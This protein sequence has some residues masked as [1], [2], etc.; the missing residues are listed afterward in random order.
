MSK[1]IVKSLII[2]CIGVLIFT[3]CGGG[4]GSAAPKPV[5]S[6]VKWSSITPPT[7]V[8]LDGIS[9]DATYTA[10]GPSFAVTSITYNGVSSASSTSIKYR[11]DGTIERITV[12]TPYTSVTWDETSGD[13]IDD[14]TVMVAAS[15]PS[16]SN[17]GIAINALHPS[18]GWEYQTFG[19]WETGR[20]TGSGTI[21]AITG[22]AQTT[23]SAIPITGNV[24]FSG[25]AAG[26]Y[27]DVAG[28]ADY[29]T[30]SS[31]SANVNFLNRSINL[32][33]TGTQKINTITAAS[34]SA[35]NLN[36]TGTLTYAPGVNSF[37]GNVSATGLSG[38]STGQFYGPNAEELGG[39]FSLTGA[40]MENFAGGYGAKQ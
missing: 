8:T 39:I 20:G 17:I 23:G 5:T 6:F 10:P 12:S 38:T 7:T 3:G 29:I 14:S 11:A 30:A 35:T 13:I 34:S 33:T 36:M 28:T 26:M 4:G 32:S 40:G 24:T 25:I 16:E 19:I 2:C 18:V 22:G 21:G 15:D 31:L 1:A 27:L 9:Q 37:A